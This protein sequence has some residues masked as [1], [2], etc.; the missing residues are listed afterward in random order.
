MDFLLTDLSAACTFLDIA[1]TTQNSATRARNV[2]NATAAHDAVRRFM[3]RVPMSEQENGDLLA[4][5]DRLEGRIQ[6]CR[7]LQCAAED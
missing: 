2:Q 1:N 7:S 6:S 3:P 5:L 4:K